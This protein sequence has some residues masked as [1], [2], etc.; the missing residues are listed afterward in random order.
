MVDQATLRNEPTT[1]S[2]NSGAAPSNGSELPPQAVARS[3]AEFLHDL[4]T[5]GELQAKL[6]M[7]D[8]KEGVSRLTVWVVVMIA[9]GI[10]AL[11]SLPVLLVTL[12][13]ALYELAGLSLTL[14]FGIAVVLGLGAS[15]GLIFAALGS[16]RKGS[17]ILERSASEWRANIRWAKDTLKR[18]STPPNR[19][20]TSRR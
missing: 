12:A 8:T 6:V 11:A 19:F 13:L 4:F 3:S 10:L 20:P 9:G 15:A 7:L 14:S 1:S 2:T 18:L 17:N 16:L 5:L